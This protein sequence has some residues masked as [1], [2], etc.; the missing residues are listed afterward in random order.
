MT[1]ISEVISKEGDSFV[2]L[3]FSIVRGTIK[4]VMPRTS[5]MFAILLPMI[6]P[7]VS[8]FRDGFTLRFGRLGSGEYHWK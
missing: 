4:A 3:C 2:N 8:C 6:F 1:I 5:P 7:R